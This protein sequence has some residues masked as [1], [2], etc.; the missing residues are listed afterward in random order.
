[1]LCRLAPKASTI[2]P[3]D[4]VYLDQ[5]GMPWSETE[6]VHYRRQPPF[7]RLALAM[8]FDG[9]YRYRGRVWW[10]PLRASVEAIG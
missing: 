8:A 7:V 2:R 9:P 1:M 4:T 6:Y 3:G 5:D 10:W